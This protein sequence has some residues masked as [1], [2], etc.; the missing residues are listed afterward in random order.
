LTQIWDKLETKT[1]KT[2]FILDSEEEFNMNTTIV[3]G[4]I[5][6]LPSLRETPNGNKVATLL[7]SSER[8]FKNPEGNYEND[9][10]RITLWKGVAETVT[11]TARKGQLVAIKGRLQ[12][13]P[14]EK[15]DGTQ[16]YFYDVIAEKVAFLTPGI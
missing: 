6:E 14:Y 11:E 15:S 7:V 5:R 1:K 4:T 13:S 8:N 2:S 10:F 12:S 16:M 3:I 9:L